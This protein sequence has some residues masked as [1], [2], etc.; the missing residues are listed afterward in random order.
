VRSAFAASVAVLFVAVLAGC[1]ETTIDKGKAE[2]LARKAV[3][4]VG[5][6]V[7][8]VSCPSGVKAKK[9]ASYDCQLVFANG[10]KATLTF[11][12][13]NDSG[14]VIAGPSDLHVQK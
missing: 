11:H 14:H 9:G 1:G 12:Q 5:V 7:K 2:D 4:H 8:S 10:Q 3:S 6:P 13:T